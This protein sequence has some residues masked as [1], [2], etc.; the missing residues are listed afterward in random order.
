MLRSY[1]RRRVEM[2]VY[3]FGNVYLTDRELGPL[4]MGVV[5]LVSLYGVVR[6]VELLFFEEEP[7]PKS[8]QGLVAPESRAGSDVPP[9]FE[10]GGS[11]T[12]SQAKKAAG[13]RPARQ[14]R[15]RQPAAAATP[16]VPEQVAPTSYV[17]PQG[18]TVILA[19]GAQLPSRIS[20]P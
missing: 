5:I 14:I 19:P 20:G 7:A 6:G 10:A 9:K 18:R 16:P 15:A 4:V 11:A 17:T 13:S 12:P 2:A 1:A 8:T 3:R